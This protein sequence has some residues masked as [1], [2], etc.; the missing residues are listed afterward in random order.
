MSWQ[1]LSASRT[2]KWRNLKQIVT[3]KPS[4]QCKL[5]PCIYHY[6]IFISDCQVKACITFHYLKQLQMISYMNLIFNIQMSKQISDVFP[7]WLL[8]GALKED[9]SMSREPIMVNTVTHVIAAS[10]ACR[11]K[12]MIVVSQSWKTNPLIGLALSLFVIAVLRVPINM[13]D[14]LLMNV[15][16]TIWQI[17]CRFITTVV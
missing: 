4:S 5:W 6:F 3:S 10:V 13:K 12:L 9:S 1:K 17:T 2:R 15:R 7:N 14:R 8:Y 11:I 16:K